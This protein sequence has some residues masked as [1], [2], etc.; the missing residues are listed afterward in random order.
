MQSNKTVR[1]HNNTNIETILCNVYSKN[2]TVIPHFRV[3]EII[4]RHHL[5]E[6]YEIPTA[7]FIS[8]LTINGLF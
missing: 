3:N 7:T 6:M 1:N 8:T 5:I 2:F 4:E